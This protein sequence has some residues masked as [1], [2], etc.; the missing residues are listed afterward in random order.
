MP[1]LK[2]NVK[3]A[4]DRSGFEVYD[5]P[6]TIPAGLYEG[7]LKSVK[8]QKTRAGDYMFRLVVELDD[9][10][11]ERKERTVGFPAF[12]NLVLME[13]EALLAREKAFYRAVCGQDDVHVVYEDGVDDGPVKV[14]KIGGKNPVG[15]RVKAEIQDDT[16]QGETR[17]VL[18]AVYPL[19]KPTTPVTSDA[20]ADEPEDEPEEETDGPDEADA[21]AREA[22][23]K[24]L[25]VAALRKI[26]KELDLD[27]DG[28]KKAELIEA[29]L[30]EE[31]GEAGDAD[32]DEGD[33]PEDE[34]DEEDEDSTDDEEEEDDESELVALE[35]E[36]AGMDRAGIKAKLKELGYDGKVL[37]S[38]SDDDLR[39]IALDLAT[40]GEKEDE[41]EE[42]AF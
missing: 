7:V 19:G 30:D 33:E 32:E 34:E 35:K 8:L 28:V 21:E 10:S 23:L 3:H 18:N 17:S 13:K 42:E 39:K 11:T 6:S 5:G 14:T 22:E 26:A 20:A 4:P 24:A 38:H 41:T 16:Y 31:F 2:R 9:K 36:L 37:K 29:I 25:G 12:G 40:G 15:V 1:S 27:T